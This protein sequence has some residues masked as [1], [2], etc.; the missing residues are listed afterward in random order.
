MLHIIF[1][2]D[3]PQYK[4]K[5]VALRVIFYPLAA[6]LTYL[7]T[8]VFLPKD[9]RPKAY[10]YLVDY[11]ITGVVAFDLLGNTLGLY[12]SVA[13]WDDLMHLTLSIPWVLVAGYTIRG[14]KLQPWVMA[15]LVVAYGATSHIIWELL[16]YLSFVRS[17]PIE[18]LTAYRD[19]MGDLTLALIGTFIGAWLSVKLLHGD[20]DRESSISK[21]TGI[22]HRVV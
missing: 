13:W 8:R 16:E 19:T 14:R 1:Y 22:A 15:G 11:C 5:A 18:S 20:I 9:R 10:P 2:A 4:D 12:D 3:L 7:V 6:A 17:N 21:P